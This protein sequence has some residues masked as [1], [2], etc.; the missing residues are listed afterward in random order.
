MIRFSNRLKYG[1]QFLLYLD[2][3]IE[4]YT[5]I[6]RAAISCEIPQKFLESIAVDLKKSGILEVKRGAGGGYRLLRHPSEVLLSDVV[7]AL[8][9]S[10][11]KPYK[12]SMELTHKVVVETLDGAIDEFWQH[13]SKITLEQMQNRYYENVDKIMYYI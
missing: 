3:D 11:L 9:K 7:K 12:E 1:L 13:L 2:V 5:D 6:Q 4:N 8:D 10:E